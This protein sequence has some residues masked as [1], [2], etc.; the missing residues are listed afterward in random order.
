MRKLLNLQQLSKTKIF[1]I[2]KFPLSC[3]NNVCDVEFVMILLLLSLINH[4]VLCV[5]IFYDYKILINSIY[6]VILIDVFH[7]IN[8]YS[9]LSS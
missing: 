1:L 3:F 4:P 6:Q 8:Q 9:K 2:G 7:L 5:Y